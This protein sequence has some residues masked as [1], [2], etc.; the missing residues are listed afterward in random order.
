VL[1]QR[2]LNDCGKDTTRT[3]SQLQEKEIGNLMK[4]LRNRN[5]DLIYVAPSGPVLPSEK[6]C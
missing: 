3:K 1:L 4:N 6:T 5:L 2:S